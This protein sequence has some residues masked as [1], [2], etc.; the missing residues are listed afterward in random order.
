MRKLLLLRFYIL[1][2][3]TLLAIFA[4]NNLRSLIFYESL[5]LSLMRKCDLFINLLYCRMKFS[6]IIQFYTFE[7]FLQTKKFNKILNLISVGK[8]KALNF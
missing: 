1:S 4:K 8:D 6:Y 5:F 2:N 3:E 7:H